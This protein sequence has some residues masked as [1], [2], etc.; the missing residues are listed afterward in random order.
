MKDI[1]PAAVVGSAILSLLGVAGCRRGSDA[2]LDSEWWRLEADRI[3]VAQ[4]IE[5][6]RLRLEKVES[7][8]GGYA[9][10]ESDLQRGVVAVERLAARVNELKGEIAARSAELEDLRGRWIRANREAASG[11]TFAEFQGAGGRSYQD[12]EIT[13]VTD[14]GIEFR[15]ATGIARLAAADLTAEQRDAFG[16]EADASGQALADERAAAEAYAS[17]VDRR[18]AE[19]AARE[20]VAAG[21]ED[22]DKPVR[23][24]LLADSSPRSR[25]SLRDEPRSFGNSTLWFP[26][27]SRSRY[28]DG[29]CPDYYY[30]APAYRASVYGAGIGFQNVRVPSANWSFTPNNRCVPTP[31][32]PFNFTTTP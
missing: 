28:R 32:R 2:A 17:W 16:L 21:R 25:S 8:E 11:R 1:T 4:K 10:R 20:E 22:A 9:D 19:N 15:H 30:V 26:R 12:V 23:G 18:V 31:V 5:L 14:I 24:P 13:R 7:H 27:Y 6:Q 3:E 29:Y